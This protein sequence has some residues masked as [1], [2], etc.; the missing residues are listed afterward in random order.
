MFWIPLLFVV[1]HA[2]QLLNNGS[3]VTVCLSPTVTT[4]TKE[5]AP[6]TLPPITKTKSFTETKSI[7]KLVNVT[8]TLNFT[9]TTTTSSSSSETSSETPTDIPPFVFFPIIPGPSSET[10]SEVEVPVKTEHGDC[11]STGLPDSQ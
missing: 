8:E 5:C 3:C 11:D 9:S 4:E 7:T 1:G 2:Q 10:P 6:K